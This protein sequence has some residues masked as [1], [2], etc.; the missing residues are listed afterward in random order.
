MASG[1]GKSAAFMLLILNV[2]LYFIVIIIASWAV[3]H[4]IVR[5]K[6]TGNSYRPSLFLS[7]QGKSCPPLVPTYLI[8]IFFLI[9]TCHKKYLQHQLC[10]FQLRSFLYSFLLETWQLVFSSYFH[11]LLEWLA[12]SPH[13]LEFR[14]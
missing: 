10:Q 13:L 3:N 11:L 8:N 4:A 12:S 5:S 2:L 1:A 9:L 6:E 7:C 14:M